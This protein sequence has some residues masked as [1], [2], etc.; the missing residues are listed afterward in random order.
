M[1]AGHLED[2][3]FAHWYAENKAGPYLQYA[4]CM[5]LCQLEK[6]CGAL[7]MSPVILLR[8]NI[9]EG[10]AMALMKYADAD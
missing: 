8:T 3:S 1:I 10:G 9:Q 6:V 4:F 2:V 7:W 5:Q